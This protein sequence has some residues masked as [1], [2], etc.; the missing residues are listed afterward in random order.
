MDGWLCGYPCV[1]IRVHVNYTPHDK[2]NGC[3]PQHYYLNKCSRSHQLQCDDRRT[4]NIHNYHKLQRAGNSTKLSA[5]LHGLS[6]AFSR[7]H[8]QVQHTD[9]SRHSSI[10]APTHQCY[11]DTDD[12]PIVSSNKN[13]P[14]STTSDAR[15][16]CSS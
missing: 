10:D 8:Y 15:P 14:L 7:P 6:G 9:S 1:S 16:L 11:A 4:N 5:S 2:C 13:G 3:K 12:S